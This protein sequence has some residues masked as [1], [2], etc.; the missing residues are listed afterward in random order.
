MRRVTMLVL[1]ILVACVLS[2]SAPSALRETPG[3]PLAAAEAAALRGSQTGAHWCNQFPA[4]DFPPTGSCPGGTVLCEGKQP[5][6]KCA[7]PLDLIY[8]DRPEEC[9]PESGHQYCS[10]YQYRQVLCRT[11]MDCLCDYVDEELTCSKQAPANTT[12]KNILLD[13]CTCSFTPCPGS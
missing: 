1:L 11:F 13:P 8:W 4:C 3:R 12:C 6:Q 2:A 5:N 10:V 9:N 7:S